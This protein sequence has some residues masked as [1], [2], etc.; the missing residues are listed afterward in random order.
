MVQ[1]DPS[2]VV[3]NRSDYGNGH[4]FLLFL[5]PATGTEKVK[6]EGEG[7]FGISTYGDCLYDQR[8]VLVCTQDG[9]VTGYDARTV[10]KLWSLPDDAANRVAPARLTVA[11]HGALYGT[12]Q[13]RQPIVLDARTGKDR[14][15][16]V[17]ATPF[18]VSK[19]AGIGV[20]EDGAPKAYPVKE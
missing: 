6:L 11:W 2:L 19:Y 10:R 13:G 16:E 5:D 3:V 17:G 4:P 9:V 8:S 15:T 18:W 12:T 14:S 1:A 7:G 20:D